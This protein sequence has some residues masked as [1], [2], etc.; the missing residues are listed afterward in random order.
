[1]PDT[2][3]P[4]SQDDP[5]IVDQILEAQAQQAAIEEEQ[6]REEAEILRVALTKKCCYLAA[7]PNNMLFIVR[8]DASAQIYD[9]ITKEFY[10]YLPPDEE[11][12]CLVAAS[13]TQ[14]DDRSPN[15]RR[16]ILGFHIGKSVN[17]TIIKIYDFQ[18]TGLLTL[19]FTDTF[20]D[21]RITAITQLS[22]GE[23]IFGT[24]DGRIFVPTKDDPESKTRL[25]SIF[26]LQD[27]SS[28]HQL[29]AT[30]HNRVFG[31]YTSP[32]GDC[33]FTLDCENE[34]IQ[35]MFYFSENLMQF[36]ATEDG[37]LITLSQNNILTVYAKDNNVE[38]QQDCSL[39]EKMVTALAVLNDTLYLGFE[40]GSLEVVTLDCGPEM[41]E[42]E[43]SEEPQTPRPGM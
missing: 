29:I 32:A 24:D 16:L 36:T 30:N 8:E 4:S 27:T 11:G 39:L 20:E 37:R 7:L 12:N 1:M 42:T 19:S 34:V 6:A 15:S 43:E 13:M 10:L 28:I 9:P 3:R 25:E 21:I 14:Y 35:K 33:I 26:T 22:S 23:V 38:F 5:S 2:R 17:N 40:D 41:E 18:P 31:A